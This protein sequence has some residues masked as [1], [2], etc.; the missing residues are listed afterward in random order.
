MR[1]M[2]GC[3]YELCMQQSSYLLCHVWCV[4]ENKKKREFI[5]RVKKGGSE[6]QKKSNGPGYMSYTSTRS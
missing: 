1:A 4:G 5:R 2:Y 6:E 3:G